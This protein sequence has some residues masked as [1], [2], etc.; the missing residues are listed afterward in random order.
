MGADDLPC[1]S[2]VKS[3]WVHERNLKEFEAGRSR[4]TGDPI[5]IV[6]IELIR[7]D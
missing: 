3:P 6:D 4:A 1:A 2:A 7:P 5:Q